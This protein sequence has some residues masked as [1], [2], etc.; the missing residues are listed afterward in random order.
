MKFPT[1]GKVHEHLCMIWCN[2][3]TDSKSLDERG[4]SLAFKFLSPKDI[5][6]FFYNKEV[7]YEK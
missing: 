5:G 3:K 4:K 1:G 2:S 6:D 7:A